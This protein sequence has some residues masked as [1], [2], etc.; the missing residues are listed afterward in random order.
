MEYDDL[1]DVNI[2]IELGTKYFAKLLKYYRRELLFSNCS[3]QCRNWN[4][5]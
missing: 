4:S 2:N 3:I 1:K 5:W